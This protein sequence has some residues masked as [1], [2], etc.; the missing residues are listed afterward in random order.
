M[1]Q[2]DQE[3][4]NMIEMKGSHTRLD[5][6]EDFLDGVMLRLNRHHSMQQ[7][8]S[9]YLRNHATAILLVFILAINS[10]SIGLGLRSYL[11]GKD[12]SVSQES[13]EMVYFVDPGQYLVYN[14]LE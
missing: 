6:G 7:R 5:A 1:S 8:V 14:H 3:I 11:S 4:M 2:P 9:G 13:P 12:A 10:V